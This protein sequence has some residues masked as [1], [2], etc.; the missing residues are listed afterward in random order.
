MASVAILR[1]LPQNHTPLVLALMLAFAYG[2]YELAIFAATPS[3]V[4]P[5]P[6]PR[7]SFR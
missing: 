2:A 4:A 7:P 6:S 3:L 1:A 5:E